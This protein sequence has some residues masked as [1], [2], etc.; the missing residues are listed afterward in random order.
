MLADAH[1]SYH[2]VFEDDCIIFSAHIVEWVPLVQARLRIS[3][4]RKTVHSE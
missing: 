3:W 1:N 4:L 2:E